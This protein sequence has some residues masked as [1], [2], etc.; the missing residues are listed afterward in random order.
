MNIPSST[1]R[2]QF[3]NG[4]DFDRAVEIVPYLQRL[5]VSHLYASPIFAAT[6]GST[7][8]Y[9]VTDQN[10]IDEV[11][12]GWNGF[13][14]L[15][16]ALKR[17]G[18]G[19]VL[20]IVPNHMAA[21]LENAWW[22]SV[23]RWGKQSPY[24]AHFDI[25]WRRKL[26]LPLLGR[27]YE[28]TLGSSELSVRYEP[29]SGSLALG[30]FDHRFPL[31]PESYPSVLKTIDDALAADVAPLLRGTRDKQETERALAAFLRGRSA[32]LD[33]TQALERKSADHA[34]VD[35]VHQE[36]P[37]RLLY[38][39]DARK[40]LS[41][42][43][44]FE[45]TGL[46][47]LRV[48][49]PKVFDDVHHLILELV[50]SGHV[51]GLRVDHVDGLADPNAYLERL[52]DEIGKDIYLVVEKI[53]AEG[54]RLPGEWPV[55][56]TTGYEFIAAMSDLLVDRAGVLELE[57]AFIDLQ[58][59]PIDLETARREAKLPI[60][61]ENFAGEL[62]RLA[63]LAEPGSALGFDDLRPAIVEMVANFPVYRTYGDRHGMTERDR[64][65]VE[66]VAQVTTEAGQN[67]NAAALGW[68]VRLLLADVPSDRTEQAG[69]FRIRFQQLTGPVMAKSVEDTLF[70]RWNSMIALNEVG[71]DPSR[72][73]RTVADFHKVMRERLEHQPYG[74]L[75]TATHD[76]KRGED[77]RARL[78]AL[79][80]FAAAWRQGVERWRK[81]HAHLLRAVEGTKVPEPEIEW[82][83]Y[84]ALAGV[85]PLGSAEASPDMLQ[86]LEARFAEY[87]EK[88]L[89][90]AKLRTSWTEVDEPYEAAVKHYARQLLASAS[91]DF[92]ESFRATVELGAVPGAV[93][94]LSQTLLKLT[95]PG[96][97][98][99]YQGAELQNL[100]LVD[101]DN[102]RSVD[103]GLL[104][105]LVASPISRPK[106]QEL[107]D[108]RAKLR[109]IA[110]GLNFRKSH[111]DLFARGEYRP[112]QVS[113]ELGDQM[114][115][116]MRSHGDSF[117]ITV[118]PRLLRSLG[119]DN[120]GMIASHLR[121]GASI[122]LPRQVKGRTSRN[123]LSGEP[124]ILDEEIA[125][126]KILSSWPVGW[127]VSVGGAAEP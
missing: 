45:V 22:R 51:Q 90:E 25:D 126:E 33:L 73:G 15:G 17:E 117:S 80:E 127:L 87:V 60:I 108:G 41:Y 103:F 72:R 68:I 93:N 115:A 49:D 113:G 92:L 84:Q 40:E 16:A 97:P 19:L 104:Q 106:E 119:A 99:I 53:L 20:D 114:I 56:G 55:D 81:M 13:E 100:S 37:W 3:R 8:G 101:P 77:A 123:L 12:G 74:L 54:E 62:E 30:Y 1:Y 58:A 125:I 82:L 116:F 5:G 98:D 29:Q 44:F 124:L 64:R 112:L 2:L 10:A 26:T 79:S 96:I 24:A 50:R 85:L 69:E 4:M 52:R 43:R 23:V 107:L 109:L 39:K 75:A 71:G 32:A 76:T 7:H 65:L 59:Q 105:Q 95:A 38:W 66:H 88:A 121:Q 34:F 122:V 46:V 67:L 6:S 48:E 102:R 94:G 63:Q 11:L 70:Y 27:P 9:D 111:P 21:S 86:A 110:T 42:R 14:R 36:Q 28:E 120:A 78:Y 61:R 118:A 89:R 57:R 91:P 18:I 31:C 35:S 47:G 83:L